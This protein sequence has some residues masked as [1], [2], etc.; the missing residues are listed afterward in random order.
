MARL[1]LLMALLALP[2]AAQPL[3]APATE[4]QLACMAGKLCAC[5]FERGGSLT[6]RPSR[7]AWDC[8]V[9]RPSCPPSDAPQPPVGL[10][11]GLTIIT[12]QAQP[13]R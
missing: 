4:G 6:G 13:W 7:F 3:C 9:L 1:I 8:G 12:P 10:P 11:P 2:A 5:R